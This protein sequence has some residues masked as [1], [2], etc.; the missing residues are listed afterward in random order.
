M[1][2]IPKAVFTKKGSAARTA[3]LTTAALK[4]ASEANKEREQDPKVI[5]KN[6]V[7]W[8]NPYIASGDLKEEIMRMK[9]QPGKDILAHGGAGFARSLASLGLIDEYKMLVHPIALGK[10]LPLFS[11]LPKPLDLKLVSSTAFKGGAV[12]HIY[13][14]A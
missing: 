3:E 8:E 4:N 9:E 10:G 14:P 13:T 12:A 7:S 6:I 11:S 5:A 1:N 2:E